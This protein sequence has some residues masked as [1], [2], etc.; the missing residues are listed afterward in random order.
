MRP[1]GNVSTYGTRC[2][3]AGWDA[4]ADLGIGRAAGTD[5]PART[6]RVDALAVPTLVRVT[7]SEEAKTTVNT[8]I[9]A[10]TIR[11]HSKSGDDIAL[12]LRHFKR[13]GGG[14]H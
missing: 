6:T 11:W 9:I 2:R 13:G 1:S 5:R 14:R 12:Q 7:A 8:A 4:D 10:K 3:D